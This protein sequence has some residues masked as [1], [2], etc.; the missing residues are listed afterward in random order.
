MA[1]R[2][3]RLVNEEQIIAAV[4]HLNE[5]LLT[6]SDAIPSSLE[7]LYPEFDYPD[8]GPE[9]YLVLL[10]EEIKRVEEKIKQAEESQDDSLQRLL[11]MLLE[12][13]TALW[14]AGVGPV[15]GDNQQD[16]SHLRLADKPEIGNDLYEPPA[17]N[18]DHNQSR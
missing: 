7:G 2:R 8:C 1:R 18:N 13:A 9:I 12:C 17:L 16:T 15:L 14:R 10:E 3:E 6:L 5:Q 11:A 4:D